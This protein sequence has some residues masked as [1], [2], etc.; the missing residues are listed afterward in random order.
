MRAFGADK[1]VVRYYD[2]EVGRSNFEAVVAAFTEAGVVDGQR[3]QRERLLVQRHRYSD[4]P[5]EG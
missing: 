3:L 1:A 4:A 2:D 5:D